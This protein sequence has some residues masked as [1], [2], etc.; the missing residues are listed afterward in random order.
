MLYCWMREHGIDALTAPDAATAM[1]YVKMHPEI[2]CVFTD[3]GLPG[4]VDGFDLGRW[5]AR[6]RP[7]LSVIFGTGGLATPC[8]DLATRAGRVF[9]KPYD[10]DRLLAAIQLAMVGD[11]VSGSPRTSDTTSNTLTKN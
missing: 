1:I 9:K 6:E 2:G 11:S 4:S 10:L 5:I 3:L 8:A 7:D